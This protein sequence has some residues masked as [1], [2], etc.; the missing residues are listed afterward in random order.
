[1]MAS[2]VLSQSQIPKR[3][4]QTAMTASV[5]LVTRAMMANVRLLN[6]DF[7]FL[8]FDNA[9]VDQFIANEFPQYSSVFNSSSIRFKNTTSSG[10]LRY[11]VMAVCSM[12]MSIQDRP[13]GPLRSCENLFCERSGSTATR[14]T[15]SITHFS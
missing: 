11:I 14:F 7:E 4:I 10:T 2:P 9:Q 15:F 13:L 3:I 5:P 1:M 8:F 12:P 6:P